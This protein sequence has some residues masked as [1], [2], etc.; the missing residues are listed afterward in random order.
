MSLVNKICG[1]FIY[2]FPKYRKMWSEVVSFNKRY[3]NNKEY[4]YRDFFIPT[5]PMVYYIQG[6]FEWIFGPN[7]FSMKMHA[8]VFNSIVLSIFFYN[9]LIQHLF[10]N[11]QTYIYLF[12]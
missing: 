9:K 12:F 2:M 8:T 5:G 7:T 1:S 11:Y 6:L 10:L 4:T 3:P